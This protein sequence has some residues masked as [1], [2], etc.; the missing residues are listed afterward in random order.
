MRLICITLLLLN[1]GYFAYVR[2]LIEPNAV[3]GQVNLEPRDVASVTLVSEVSVE[4]EQGCEALGP[5]GGLFHGQQAVEQLTALGARVYLKAI[6]SQSDASSYRV[7]LPAAKSRRDAFR[8][9][10]E[11][12]NQAI[13]S[14]VITQGKD[15]WAISLGVFST[16]SA[17]LELQAKIHSRGYKPVISESSKYERQFW[18]F[19]QQHSRLQL[20]PKILA[21]IEGI[22]PKVRYQ[23]KQCPETEN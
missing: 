5:F 8:K 10:E 23:K 22:D 21:S 17:A 3:P 2:L 12:K 11:L 15:T 16:A 14:Y 6:D 7:I 4:A 18:V 1:L 19:A 20:S 13:D 9:L